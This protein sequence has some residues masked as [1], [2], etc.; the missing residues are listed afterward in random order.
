MREGTSST[1]ACCARERERLYGTGEAENIPESRVL[2]SLRGPPHIA[3]CVDGV[4]PSSAKRS[5]LR[6]PG[7]TRTLVTL[8]LS[9]LYILIADAPPLA[10]R[11]GG[12]ATLVR[13]TGLLGRQVAPLHYAICLYIFELT[14]P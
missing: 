10:I 4:A 7:C 8:A 13:V 12:V 1:T 6:S 2:S 3:G 5:P 14:T 11:A 9:W